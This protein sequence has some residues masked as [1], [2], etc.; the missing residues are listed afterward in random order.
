MCLGTAYV[1]QDMFEEYT[2][3]PEPPQTQSS[4]PRPRTDTE[5]TAFEIQLN[6]LLECLN[7]FGTAGSATSSKT[8]KWRKNGDDT[9]GDN[10]ND[11]G[12]IDRYF[13]S[14]E[15]GTAMR[16]SYSGSGYPLTLFM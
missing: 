5:I 12:P 6:T 15:K 14:G 4:T 11:D 9:G 16:M 13:A 10:V 3:Q 8:K 2:Y 7:I 1:F